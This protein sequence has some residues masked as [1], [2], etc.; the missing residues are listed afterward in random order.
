MSDSK[1][2]FALRKQG[3]TQEALELGRQV[4]QQNKSDSWNVRALGW[5]LH[6]AIKKAGQEKNAELQKTLI[7]ELISMPV[8]SDD[9]ILFKTCN[10]WKDRLGAGIEDNED[11]K[12]CS[13]LRKA[14]QLDDAWKLIEEVLNKNPKSG[15]AWNER[16]WI[17]FSYLKEELNNEKPNGNKIEKLFT[18]YQ[19]QEMH[20]KPGLLHSMMLNQAVRASRYEVFE[21]FVTFFQWWEP[22]TFF[23]PED[24][25]PFEGQD[26][27]LRASNPVKPQSLDEKSMSALNKSLQSMK[28]IDQEKLEWADQTFDGFLQEKPQHPWAPLWRS[29]TLIAMKR[30][31]DARS[32]LVPFART[33]PSQSWVWRGLAETYPIEDDMHLAL[34]S[35]AYFCGQ[36]AEEIFSLSIYQMLA[37]ALSN[38]EKHSEALYF[39]ERIQSVRLQKQYKTEEI[40]IQLAQSIYEGVNVSTQG[41]IDRTLKEIAH[42]AQNVLSEGLPKGPGV[43]LGKFSNNYNNPPSY[44]VG[45]LKN[46]ILHSTPAPKS[47]TLPNSMKPGLPLEI[48]FDERDGR[49]FAAAVREVDGELWEGV[50]PLLGVVDHINKSKQ[51]TCVEIGKQTPV[52]IYHDRIR[53]SH[54]LIPGSKILMYCAQVG[55][56]QR[57]QAYHIEDS[58]ASDPSWLDKSSG[59]FSINSPN[60][61]GFVESIKGDSAFVSPALIER[62][63]LK[64][65]DHLEFTMILKWN[66]TRNQ[67][68][69]SVIAIH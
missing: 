10:F 50:T 54:T 9:E 48:T 53:D 8:P 30:T 35:Q 19:S 15:R 63:Q 65:G 2:V 43:F 32:L 3:R 33:K 31:E 27:Q 4:Y 52:L 61:F 7:R 29:K 42:S 5:S 44:Y 45:I 37:D 49:F 13:T 28:D 25:V 34:L 17:L 12:N 55:P 66:K 23:R 62:K 58:E 1:T 68:G 69:W 38:R 64:D 26:P 6:D 40:D 24:R 20:E 18:Q 56:Q 51:L 21:A 47:H 16:G 36:A 14:G 22:K 67:M 41:E 60:P 39:L 46:G 59:E 57:L 11:L